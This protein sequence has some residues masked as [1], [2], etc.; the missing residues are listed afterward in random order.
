MVANIEPETAENK[1]VTWSVSD[2]TLAVIDENGLVTARKNGTVYIIATANDN[3]LQGELLISIRGQS[4]ALTDNDL[5]S[6]QVYPVPAQNILYIENESPV[7]YYRI[8]SIEG[9][10]VMKILNPDRIT[11]V[12]IEALERG[13]YFVVAQTKTASAVVRFVK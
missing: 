7:I 5:S 6:F 10:T 1:S 12:N 11:Q 3:G 13:A 2:T 9:K 4:T 8:I